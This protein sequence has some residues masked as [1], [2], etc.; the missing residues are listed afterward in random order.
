MKSNNVKLKMM[1]VQML[2]LKQG[3]ECMVI[4]GQ[5][6]LSNLLQQIIELGNL[7]KEKVVVNGSSQIL[8][9]NGDKSPVVEQEVVDKVQPYNGDSS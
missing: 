2:G 6:Q 5:K 1:K 7:I 4:E 9:N 3:L 8:Y